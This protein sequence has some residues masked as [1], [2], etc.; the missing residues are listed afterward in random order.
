[1]SIQEDSKRKSKIVFLV[2]FGLGLGKDYPIL[3]I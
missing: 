2:E 3:S 1:M